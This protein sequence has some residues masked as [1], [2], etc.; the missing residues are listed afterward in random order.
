MKLGK[1]FFINGKGVVIFV[2]R[3]TSLIVISL[4]IESTLFG[5]ASFMFIVLTESLQCFETGKK[6]HDEKYFCCLNNTLGHIPKFCV[7]FYMC[8]DFVSLLAEICFCDKKR[9][10]LGYV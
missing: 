2:Q 9:L 4:M 8:E 6:V 7:A 1:L 3:N 10:Q 5:Q